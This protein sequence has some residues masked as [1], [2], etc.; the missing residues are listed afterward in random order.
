MNLN[1]PKKLVGT[2]AEQQN[3]IVSLRITSLLQFAIILGL[4]IALWKT[5][6]E[7]TVYIPPDLSNGVVMNL[8]DVPKATVLSTVSYLWIE[9]NSWVKN[10]EKDAFS[11]LEAYQDYFSPDFREKLERSYR[12]LKAKGELDRIRKVTLVP[13][14]IHDVESRVFVKVKNRAW[15][16]YLDIIVEDYY[17][18]ELVQHVTARYPLMVERVE[19]NYDKNPLGLKITGFDKSPTIIREVKK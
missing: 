8:G 6:D 5:Q 9:V 18:G 11:N 4:L 17:L 7:I 10:G 1:L 14:M 3:H 15:I 13:G 12:S 19:T 16:V 2:L